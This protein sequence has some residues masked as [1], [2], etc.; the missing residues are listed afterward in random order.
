[1]RLVVNNVYNN[2][3]CTLYYKTLKYIVITSELIKYIKI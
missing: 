1:M 2:Q 3:S